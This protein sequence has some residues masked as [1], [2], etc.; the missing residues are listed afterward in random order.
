VL[1]R[2]DWNAGDGANPVDGVIFDHD[3]NLYG[4]TISGGT[5]ACNGNCGTVFRLS[6]AKNGPW[7]EQLLYSFVGGNDGANPYA[8]LV[9]DTAGSLYGTT[10]QGGIYGYGTVFGLTSSGGEWVEAVLYSFRGYPNDGEGANSALV[11]DKAGSLYGT[12]ELGGDHC[13]PYGCG[14]VF[15]LLQGSNGDWSESVLYSFS[16]DAD[17][18]YPVGGLIFHGKGDLYGATSGSLKV[19]A[20]TVFELIPASGG[21]WSEHALHAFKFG[22]NG[23]GSKRGTQPSGGIVTK[24]GNLY[25]VTSLGGDSG[26][27][28]GNGCGVV[29]EITP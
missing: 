23:E 3:G 15:K 13:G 29:F 21:N 18:R 12:T 2:F 16:G 11:L 25:G 26:C 10:S 1:H 4:T 19:Q 14:T 5:G 8:G 27:D 7:K 9:F 24:A 22:K 28:G 17:D 6:P 20:G